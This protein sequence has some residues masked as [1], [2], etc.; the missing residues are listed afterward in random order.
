MAHRETAKQKFLKVHHQMSAYINKEIFA[1]YRE[2]LEK[3]GVSRFSDDLNNY[4]TGV[5][6]NGKKSA[7][8]QIYL[9]RKS[10][11]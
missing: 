1:K 10:K 3:I 5:A 9:D 6:L 4:V 8:E 2:E 11:H 7:T